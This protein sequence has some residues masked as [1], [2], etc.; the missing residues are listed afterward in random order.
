MESRGIV[1]ILSACMLIRIL[2]TVPKQ[3][4]TRTMLHT[5]RPKY[6]TKGSTTDKNT[7]QTVAHATRYPRMVTVLMCTHL[8][9]GCL[10]STLRLFAYGHVGVL[11]QMHARRIQKPSGPRWPTTR[12]VDRAP[13]SCPWS[14]LGIC[15][16]L[17]QR[18]PPRVSS[19]LES[20]EVGL[21]P[22]TP[23]NTETTTTTT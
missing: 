11:P 4:L 3:S 14:A 13:N 6:Y 7:N 22:L 15:L 10:K 1:E 21:P 17:L 19:E 12:F 23:W 2:L 5:T 20:F 18:D 16:W 8:P 9:I